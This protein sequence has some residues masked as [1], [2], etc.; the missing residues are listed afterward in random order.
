MTGAAPIWS[1]KI[2]IDDVPEAG[3]HIDLT[4]DETIRAALAQAAGLRDLSRLE[5]SLDLKRHGKNGLRVEGQMSATVGQ[6][7]VVSLEPMESEISED[8]DLT[9]TA[10]GG[11]SIAD[12]R[13]EAT[14]RFG[15]A[16][17]PEPLA[18]GVVDLGAIVTEFLLLGVDPYPRKEGAVFEPPAVGDTSEKPFAALAALKKVKGG[19]GS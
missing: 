11:S 5:A 4:A 6:N 15:E 7:C 16:E 19:E 14:M 13:G 18:G 12:E 9:F 1:E 17:P 10:S 3:A 8:I 2:S